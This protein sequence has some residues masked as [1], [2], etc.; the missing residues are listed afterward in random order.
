MSS[1][2]KHILI[3]SFLIILVS[4]TINLNNL[5]N[6]SDQYIPEYITNDNTALNA[7]SDEG[8]TL[9]RVLFYDKNL[10][11]DGTIACASCHNQEFA[12]S[13]T[14]QVSSG[15]NGVTGRHSM[16]LVNARFGGETRF[17][18][19]ERA[20]TLEEQTTM[21]IQDH[22]EMGYSGQNGDPSIDDLITELSQLHYYEELFTFVY[23][24]PEI[25]ED[26]MQR[27]LAQFI[28]SIQSFDSKYDEG[29]AMVTGNLMPFPNFTP[30]ENRGKVLFALDPVF[31][32]EGNR[33][34]GGAGCASC[35]R[36]PDFA[37]DP[38][39]RTNGV[40]EELNGSLNFSIHRAPTLRDMF[41]PVTGLPNGQFMHNGAFETI[42]EVISHYNN[43]GNDLP[44]SI[45][46]Q[47]DP[48]LRSLNFGQKL[49][50]SDTESQ[51]L[52]NFLH[53]LTGSDVY[54]NL[55]WSDPF[56]AN[57]NI[58]IIN[59]PLSIVQPELNTLAVF[60][61]PAIDFI[62]I[63]SESPL[64]DIQ[65]FDLSGKE[66]LRDKDITNSK[67]RI[68]VS[69]YEN[70]IYLIKASYQGVFYFNKLVINR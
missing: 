65:I 17:F 1:I 63:D 43:I 14:A 56:D 11:T 25:T 5:Y 10:S 23:G 59:D 48:R 21:P 6:Y 31:G 45:I 37:I 13:D 64:E 49:N 26:R 57:G 52:V 8:A 54:T 4:G 20:E 24:D 35:H 47:L 40:V 38:L 61:N 28:R 66:V 69:G 67:T 22:A 44:I 53:T 16:R 32:E 12:F 27:A 70:G 29:R 62:T 39:S 60:P 50:L 30:S 3:V 18:W 15:V 34:D 19:D 68:D 9:G 7:L 36:A 42:E 41:N 33:E 2:S 46:A 51:D 55:K 58:E